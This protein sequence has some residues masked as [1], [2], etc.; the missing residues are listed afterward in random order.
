MLV[1]PNNPINLNWQDF[2]SHFGDIRKIEIVDSK[3]VKVSATK[4]KEPLVK[5]LGDLSLGDEV[6]VNVKWFSSDVRE[7]SALINIER[8]GNF[9]ACQANNADHIPAYIHDY[10]LAGLKDGI[11]TPD[12]E[13]NGILIDGGARGKYILIV[14]PE[15]DFSEFVEIVKTRLHLFKLNSDTSAFSILAKCFADNPYKEYLVDGVNHR[16]HHL[17]EYNITIIFQLN[18][19]GQTLTFI[20]DG[21]GVILPMSST[22]EI[23]RYLNNEFI[24]S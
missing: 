9:I 3:S 11:L 19:D 13:S 24:N 20:K 14:N 17:K 22:V 18:K 12:T 4:F 10:I 1:N 8:Y 2:I 6:L 23:I 5:L 15:V 16:E 21:N 7:Y